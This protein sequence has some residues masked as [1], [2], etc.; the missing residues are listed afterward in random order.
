M[1]TIPESTIDPFQT[2]EAYDHYW[3]VARERMDIFY[4]RLVNLPPPWTSD[5]IFLRY[6]FTN[7]YRA[8]DRTSQYLIHHVIY[9]HARDGMIWT[10]EDTLFR[11][12]LFKMFNKIETWELLDNYNKAFKSDIRWHGGASYDKFIEFADKVL[13]QAMA[14]KDKIF[15]AAYIM[16]SGTQLGHHNK[17]RNVLEAIKL[18]MNMIV[19]QLGKIKSMEELYLLLLSCPMMGPFI[20]FQ[21]TIDLNYSTLFD[22]DEDS[23]V[24]AGPGAKSGIEKVFPQLISTGKPYEAAIYKMREWQEILNGRD[25]LPYQTLFGRPLKLIDLQNL[26]CE[27]DKYT[28]VSLPNLPNPNGRTQIKQHFTASTDIVPCYLPPKWGLN[29]KISQWLIANRHPVFLR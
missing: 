29:E 4:R 2:S 25:Q 24:V 9:A 5:S 8:L 19:P 21:L 18:A 10:P 7:A 13:S 6:K 27:T 11:I 16:P 20:A 26:F 14:D 12:L 28:R 3:H 1:S 15:S 17:H 22:F 23:F